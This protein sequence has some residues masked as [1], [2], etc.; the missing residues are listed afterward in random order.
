MKLNK[1][2]LCACLCLLFLLTHAQA[3]AQYRITKSVLAGGC[4]A[5]SNTDLQLNNTL[6]QA[7]IG[8]TTTESFI[9]NLG[10]WA[11]SGIIPVDSTMWLSNLTLEN[12]ADKSL[13][14]SFG[15]AVNATDGLDPELGEIELPPPPPGDVLDA[16]FLLPTGHEAV[17]D[18]RGP[19]NENIRWSFDF[20]SGAGGYPM[21]FRWDNNLLPAGAFY[22][23]DAVTEGDIILINMKT[24]SS[25]TLTNS[26]IT[27]LFI[28]MSGES[29][30]NVACFN[31]WNL[32]SAPVDA[33]DM[34]VASLFPTATSDAF[35]FDNGYVSVDALTT[36]KG[37]WLKFAAAETFEIC[38]DV[39]DKVIPVTTGWNIIG[40]FDR[41]V[42]TAS[43]TSEPAGIIDSEFFGYQNGYQTATQLSAGKGYWIKVSKGG[44]LQLPANGMHKGLASQNTKNALT[45]LTNVTTLHFQDRDN[46]VGTLYL[47]S[48]DNGVFELPPVPPK[49]GFDIRF[50]DNTFVSNSD[51]ELFIQ[52]EYPIKIRCENIN[53]LSLILKDAI[54]NAQWQE[55]LQQDAEITIATPMDRLFISSKALPTACE[56]Q[57]NYPNPF[58][59]TTTIRFA[60]AQAGQVKLSVYNLLGEKVADLLDKKC[61][62]GYH[63]VTFESN[64][65]SSGVYFYVMQTPTFTDKKKMILMR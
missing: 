34:S 52:A 25:Y 38:G 35:G 63:K 46:R 5:G 47:A 27:S 21:T 12:A 2:K 45:R 30:V 36:G 33:A 13:M 42:P 23:K 20:Q 49:G 39:V 3:F 48:K 57:Q 41:D 61:E 14:L 8:S 55:T 31:G 54:E 29:C 10:F 11:T 15:Q 59:P 53:D 64:G 19:E 9:H 17:V 58:N 43:I 22:L 44:T 18:I 62:A 60:L 65:L 4:V 24:Q 50:S 56:L 51:A 7:L 40:P 6:G 28:D 32:V 37:Y 16:R 1:P 26:A